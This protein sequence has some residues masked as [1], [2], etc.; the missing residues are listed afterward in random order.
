[1]PA[2]DSDKVPDEIGAR[3]DEAIRDLSKITYPTTAETLLFS[4]RG[5][6]PLDRLASRYGLPVLAIIAMIIAIWSFGSP[7]PTKYTLSILAASL[8]LLG[9]LVF[10]LFNLVGVIEEKALNLQT[11]TQVLFELF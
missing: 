7:Q 1:M 10:H 5:V 4:S 3:L 6:R 2:S 9:A 8:G 11:C